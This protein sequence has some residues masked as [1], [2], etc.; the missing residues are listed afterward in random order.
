M[1][2]TKASIPEKKKARELTLRKL[3]AEEFQEGSYKTKL[4]SENEGTISDIG[5]I[6]SADLTRLILENK[7]DLDT[8]INRHVVTWPVEKLSHVDKNIL[9][10]A[11]MELKYIDSVPTKVAVNEAVEMAKKYGSENSYKFVNGVLGSVIQEI[12]P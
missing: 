4:P 11:V 2:M 10:I 8:I 12:I 6:L 5:E 7:N 9:R 3:Y 1:L